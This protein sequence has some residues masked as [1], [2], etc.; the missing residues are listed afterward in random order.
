VNPGDPAEAGRAPASVK[1]SLWT[2]ELDPW[3]ALA[4]GVLGLVAVGRSLAE[5]LTSRSLS[6]SGLQ[7]GAAGVLALALGAYWFL[8]WRVRRLRERLARTTDERS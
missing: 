5:Y 3:I 6:D 1:R 8:R 2:R 4:L 7:Q